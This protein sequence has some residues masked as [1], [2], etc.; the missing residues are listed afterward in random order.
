MNG[1]KNQPRWHGAQ[2]VLAE[3]SDA[4]GKA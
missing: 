1:L 3:I 4:A 2:A